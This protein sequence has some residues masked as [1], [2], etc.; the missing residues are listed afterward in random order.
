MSVEVYRSSRIAAI[1]ENKNSRFGSVSIATPRGAFGNAGRQ[2]RI[3]ENMNVPIAC[4][5]GSEQ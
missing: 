4:A 3:D 1:D 5:L 2:N